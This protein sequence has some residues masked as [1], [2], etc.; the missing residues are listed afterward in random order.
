[1]TEDVQRKVVK[2]LLEEVETLKKTIENLSSRKI[3]C[4]ALIKDLTAPSSAT[5][6]QS[7]QAAGFHVSEAAE[8]SETEDDEYVSESDQDIVG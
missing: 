4:E 8:E 6:S 2:E 7:G 3:K 5:S 1:M